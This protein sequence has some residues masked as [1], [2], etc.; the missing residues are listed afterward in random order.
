MKALRFYGKSDLRV[1]DVAAPKD[2]GSQQVVV[3]VICCGICGTD[4]HEYVAGPI[5]M[6][7]QQILGMNFLGQ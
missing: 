7:N 3:K 4:L 6:S 2:C 1:E 5:F